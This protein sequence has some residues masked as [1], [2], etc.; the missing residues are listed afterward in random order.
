MKSREPLDPETTKMHQDG[1]KYSLVFDKTKPSDAGFYT[2]VASNPAGKTERATRLSIRRKYT[3][4][5]IGS[6][7]KPKAPD[8]DPCV[9]SH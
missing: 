4:L 5:L 1:N 6:L 7:V 8:V 3:Y 9:G 2:C